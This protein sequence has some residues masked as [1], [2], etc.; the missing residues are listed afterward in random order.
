M[1]KHY[2]FI[3]FYIAKHKIQRDKNHQKAARKAT[4]LNKLAA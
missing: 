3:Y 2:Q 4:R 1:H